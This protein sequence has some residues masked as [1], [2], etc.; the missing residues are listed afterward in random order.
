MGGGLRLESGADLTDRGV[1]TGGALSGIVVRQI[2]MYIGEKTL[3]ILLTITNFIFR[4]SRKYL[5]L[6]FVSSMI[7]CCII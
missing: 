6:A 5:T 3:G 4:V 7:D 1:R 2:K